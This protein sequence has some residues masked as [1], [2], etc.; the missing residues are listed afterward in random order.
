[1]KSVKYF[2][3]SIALFSLIS[4][5]QSDDNAN[6][7]S[8]NSNIEFQ[9]RGIRNGIN[10]EE[11]SVGAIYKYDS[12]RKTYFFH[13]SGTLLNPTTILT[14]KH[15]V[16]NY[17][18]TGYQSGQLPY[19]LTSDFGFTTA[20]NNAEINVNNFVLSKGVTQPFAV[21]V[22]TSDVILEDIA[23]IKLSRPYPGVNTFLPVNNA[24]LKLPIRSLVQAI[25]YG[26][27]NDLANSS[28]T[29][30]SGDLA[31]MGGRR[32][33]IS[34]SSFNDAELYLVP[35]TATKQLACSGDSGGPA[36]AIINGKRTIVGVASTLYSTGSTPSNQISCVKGAYNTHVNV[37]YFN[38]FIS[39][40]MNM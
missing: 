10:S 19:N 4:C 35:G 9:N 1:M 31:Y 27:F 6:R 15:C 22:V 7:T 2:I 11:P 20:R 21:P 8:S 33:T 24:P 26:M 17:R 13:C 34:Y 25:G 30:R 29:K 14:A 37:Y 18:T 36:I 5:S 38:Q 23:I 28:G 16:L 39:T 12:V 32:G 40:A 3:C